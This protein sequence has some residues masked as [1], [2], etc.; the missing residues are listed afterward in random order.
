M[1]F[2]ARP[3]GRTLQMDYNGTILLDHEC[4]NHPNEMIPLSLN[5]HLRVAHSSDFRDVSLSVIARMQLSASP[6]KI[7]L[8]IRTPRVACLSLSSLIA[9]SIYDLL[10]G[11]KPY[12]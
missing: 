11:V 9:I 7:T 1:P 10:T 12:V 6:A 3:E 5:A 4:H 8:R 2:I